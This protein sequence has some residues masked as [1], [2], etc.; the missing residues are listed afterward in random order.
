[1]NSRDLVCFCSDVSPEAVVGIFRDRVCCFVVYLCVLLKMPATTSGETSEQNQTKPWP[2]SPKT[3]HCSTAILCCRNR[4]SYPA[5]ILGIALM[6]DHWRSFVFLR[7]VFTGAQIKWELSK[8]ASTFRGAVF[9]LMQAVVY[10]NQCQSV[11][12]LPNS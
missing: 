10:T 4:Q 7:E 9:G 11:H 2:F 1:M 3:Y 6:K 5:V 12:W 8:Q